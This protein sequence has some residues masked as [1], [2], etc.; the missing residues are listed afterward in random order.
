MV[1]LNST[2]IIGGNL[3][4]PS[5]AEIHGI[6]TCLLDGVTITSGSTLSVDN[7]GIVNL[8]GDLINKGTIVIGGNAAQL[9]AYDSNVT[10]SG[11]GT[12]ILSDASSILGGNGQ[13]SP[14]VNE[15]NTIQGQGHIEAY[16]IN[17]GTVNANVAGG[18]ITITVYSDPP[19]TTPRTWGRW[20]PPAAE[21][22]TSSRTGP[23]LDH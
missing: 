13:L 16:L 19:S 18:T 1:D 9:T 2:Q 6:V 11:G 8:T 10:L 17:Q 7:G 12:V 14:L 22:C 5:G 20:R 23:W 3:T 15:D 4:S 21:R